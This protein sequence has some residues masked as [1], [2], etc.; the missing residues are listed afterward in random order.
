[1][2]FFL[3]NQG[4]AQ[5]N[6]YSNEWV[7]VFFLFSNMYLLLV[8]RYFLALAPRAKN[9]LKYRNWYFTELTQYGQL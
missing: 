3:G 4:Y 2:F 6:T 1:M 5:K 9:S 8:E 7:G